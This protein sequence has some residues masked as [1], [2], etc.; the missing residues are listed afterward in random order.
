MAMVVVTIQDA[1]DGGIEMRLEVEPLT[2]LG[3]VDMATDTP[4]MTLGRAMVRHAVHAAATL[5][6]ATNHRKGTL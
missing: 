1:T 5:A 4:S 2:T 6:A 3:P